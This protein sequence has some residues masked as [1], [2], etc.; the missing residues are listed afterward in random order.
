VTTQAPTLRQIRDI[1]TNSTNQ[2]TNQLNKQTNKNNKNNKKTKNNNNNRES[3]RKILTPQE[4][5]IRVLL[6]KKLTAALLGS[7][8]LNSTRTFL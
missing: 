6:T 2:P 1:L 5:R 7:L 4:S 8:P 3:R